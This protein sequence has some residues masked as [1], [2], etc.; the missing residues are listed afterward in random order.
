MQQ[1][2]R[3]QAILQGKE[4]GLEKVARA[5]GILSVREEERERGEREGELVRERGVY[6]CAGV[7]S[8]T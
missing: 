6:C 7:S 2:A 4:R 5:P 3:A 1:V 8:L